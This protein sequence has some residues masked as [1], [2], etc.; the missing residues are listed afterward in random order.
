MTS[1]P[2]D[3]LEEINPSECVELLRTEQVGRIGVVLE[4]HPEIFPVNYALDASDAVIFRTAFGTKLAAAINHH[5][6]FEVDRI[7]GQWE[8][9]WSVIVH[10]VAQQTEHVLKGETALSTWRDNAPYL[11][12]ISQI[13]ISGRRLRSE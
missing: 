12:R 3:Q 9:G 11:V 8:A 5:V 10:G 13:S 1:D 4:G 2:D 7:D 6:V